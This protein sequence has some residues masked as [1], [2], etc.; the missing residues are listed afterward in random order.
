MTAAWNDTTR[1]TSY[2]RTSAAILNNGGLM[3]R[4]LVIEHLGQTELLTGLQLVKCLL[5]EIMQSKAATHLCC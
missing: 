2:R 1:P 3:R 5:A 4:G